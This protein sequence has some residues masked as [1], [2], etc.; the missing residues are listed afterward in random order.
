MDPSVPPASH[1]ALHAELDTEQTE[2]NCCEKR[3]QNVDYT[4]MNQGGGE[5]AI[6]FGRGRGEPVVNCQGFCRLLEFLGW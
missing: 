5:G 4:V 3:C 1:R 2:S 6:P